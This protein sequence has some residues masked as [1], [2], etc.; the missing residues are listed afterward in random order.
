MTFQRVYDEDETGLLGQWDGE[1]ETEGEDNGCRTVVDVDTG[2]PVPGHGARD[3][4][5]QMFGAG[6]RRIP[7]T[8]RWWLRPLVVVALAGPLAFFSISHMSQ[9]RSPNSSSQDRVELDAV[10]V[11]TPCELAA[12]TANPLVSWWSTSTTTITT[13][14]ITTATTTTTTI[15]C[16]N[17]VTLNFLD[18]EKPQAWTPGHPV[19]SHSN[20]NGEGPDSGVKNL[21]FGK[22]GT[23]GGKDFDLLVSS[24]TNKYTAPIFGGSSYAKWNGLYEG[25]GVIYMTNPGLMDLKFQFVE[26]GTDT[27]IVLPKYYFTFLDVDTGTP[28]CTANGEGF[29]AAECA[30]MGEPVTGDQTQGGEIL[31]VSDHSQHFLG[32]DTELQVTNNVNGDQ[33]FTATVY[34]KGSDNPW[35]LMT[36]PLTALQKNR[37]AT[38]L[39]EDKSEFEISYQSAPGS[40]TPG[41]EMLFTGKTSLADM[42]CAGA[43]ADAA[44]P[45]PTTAAPSVPTPDP[46]DPTTPTP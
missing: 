27:P 20:L 8:S 2:E 16:G 15:D 17:D 21:R 44:T 41:R 40:S 24:P 39:F 32:P 46:E 13:T 23:S 36:V 4:E 28:A 25:V 38:L 29:N 14:T 43:D 37:A 35:D 42:P 9:Q 1:V 10:H 7:V 3:L 31:A 12:T 34:G 30:A 22:V 11:A 19:V 18:A 33:V 26:A 6:Q 5:F 45:S